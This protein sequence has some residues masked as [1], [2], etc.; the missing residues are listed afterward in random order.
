MDKVS[1]KNGLGGLPEETRVTTY[2]DPFEEIGDT[3]FRKYCEK[4]IKRMN[5]KSDTR[6][7]YIHTRDDGFIAIAFTR[8][9]AKNRDEVY[10]EMADK[11][12]ILAMGCENTDVLSVEFGNEFAEKVEGYLRETHA[13]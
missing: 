3:T 4:D 13:D 10:K 7:L 5:A 2:C 6:K 12:R 11:I 8:M 9:Y 1:R